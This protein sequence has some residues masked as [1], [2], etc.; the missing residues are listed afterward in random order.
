MKKIFFSIVISVFFVFFL[1][2][3]TG[4]DFEDKDTI[5]SAIPAWIQ[6][7]GSIAAIIYSGMVSANQIKHEKS[8]ERARKNEENIARLDIVRALVIRSLGLV[9]EVK[10]AL[11][12]GT[13]KSMMQV[14]PSTMRD[15]QKAMEQLPL[16]DIPNGMLALDVITIGPN[17][18]ILA[19]CW[20]QC[21]NEAM[22][23]ASKEPS[24]ESIE[25]LESGSNELFTVCKE[26]LKLADE[27][28]KAF[29]SESSTS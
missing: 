10:I 22:K 18:G 14:S 26:A 29:R 3:L 21:A 11:E 4:L 1:H 27:Q 5:K 7:F 20:E 9:S 24:P 17:L 23:S 28:L 19:D 16:F 15:T 13:P 25:N 8:V 2:F 12:T 6:A